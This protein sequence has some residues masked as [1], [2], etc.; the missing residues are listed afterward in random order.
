[1]EKED[2]GFAL[3]ESGGRLV[4]ISINV[5]L[6]CDGQLGF[7]EKLFVVL[8]DPL[9]TF[10]TVVT[11]STALIWFHDWRSGR[12]PAQTARAVQISLICATDRKNCM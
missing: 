2:D 8:L 10:T 12:V 7:E 9:V 6:R 11:L 1:L 5:T 3:L 4:D